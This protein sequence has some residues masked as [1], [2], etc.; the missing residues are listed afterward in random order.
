MFHLWNMKN[1][2]ALEIFVTVGKLRN[3]SRAAELLGLT[4]ST[5]SRQIQSL[6]RDL[7]VSLIKRDPRHF[8]LTDEGSAFLKRA[9]PIIDQTME[10]FDEVSSIHSGIKGTIRIS[11][12]VDLSLFYLAKSIADFSIENPEVEF[13]IDLSPGLVDLKTDGFDMALRVGRLK[14][15][16][17]YARKLN[18]H[19]PGFFATPEYLERIVRPKNI[20]DLTKHTLVATGKVNVDGTTIS[21]TI[22]ANNMSVVKQ[23]TLKGA[24]IGLLSDIVVKE[25]KKEGSLIQI[26][27]GLILPKVPIYLLFPQKKMPKRISVFAQKVFESRI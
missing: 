20:S 13:L 1:L 4:K 27:P 16:T 14:D 7:G 2:A 3:F 8:S 25:E 9:E 21:P 19:Q 26:L 22:A 23:L 6:E 5:V 24:G 11:T 15:S 10:A 12:T 18:E 17:L